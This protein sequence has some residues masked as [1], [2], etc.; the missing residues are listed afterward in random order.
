MTIMTKSTFVYVTYISATPE[1]VAKLEAFKRRM[2]WSFK[3]VSAGENGFN[4]D[5]YVSFKPDEVARGEIYH[6]YRMV[7]QSLAELPGISAFYKDPDGTVFHTYSCYERGV[8]TVNGAYHWLDLMPKGRDE[9]GLSFTMGW[10]RH[11]DRY[12]SDFRGPGAPDSGAMGA[13]TSGDRS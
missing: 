3:W 4:Y 7:K 12:G 8:E 11:H 1:Q 10:V 2:G 9:E 5:Y 6:N 13:E